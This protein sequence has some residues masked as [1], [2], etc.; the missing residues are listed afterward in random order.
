MKFSQTGVCVYLIGASG[1]LQRPGVD[2]A[3]FAGLGATGNTASNLV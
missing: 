2:A 3:A 1:L